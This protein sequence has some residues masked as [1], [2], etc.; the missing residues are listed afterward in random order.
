VIGF[1]TFYG[2]AAGLAAAILSSQ[3]FVASGL[4]CTNVVS[5]R[6]GYS[7][8]VE[9]NVTLAGSISGFW[10]EWARNKAAV[11]ESLFTW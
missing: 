6:N 4:D 5:H 1:I 9:A 7:G 10:D 2:G 3:Q 11:A 8:C